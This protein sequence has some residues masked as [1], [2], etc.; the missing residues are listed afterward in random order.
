MLALLHSPCP[1]AFHHH[2]PRSKPHERITQL[3]N[4][5]L[6]LQHHQSGAGLP[7]EACNLVIGGDF[8]S[9]PDESA[10]QLLA[11]GQLEAGAAE[12][13]VQV[14]DTHLSHPYLLREVYFHAAAA[15]LP[16]TRQVGGR[17]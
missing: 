11:S 14:T 15:P 7:P 4:A 17:A 3:K 1:A 2:S 8:N 13:G 9:T 6:A 16:F 5:L 10:W 12:R